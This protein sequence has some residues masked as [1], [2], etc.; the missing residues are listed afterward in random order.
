MAENIGTYIVSVRVQSKLLGSP[1]LTLNLVVEAASG[2]VVGMGDITQAVT[3]EAP[4][5]HVTQVTGQINYGGFTGDP[6]QL[7]VHLIGD[8]VWSAP[9]PAIGTFQG[10]FSAALAVSRSWSGTGSFVYGRHHVADCVVGNISPG[11]TDNGSS[12]G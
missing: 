2:R 11:S 7:F 6:D 9:P 1:V 5:V 3:P 4:Q 10:P 8:Y 12:A